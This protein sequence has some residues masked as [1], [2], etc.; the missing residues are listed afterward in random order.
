MAKGNPFLSTLQGRIGD[1]TFRQRKGVQVS[2]KL[3]PNVTNPRSMGQMSQRTQLSNLVAFYRT[4]RALLARAFEDKKTSQSDYNKFVQLN[5]NGETKI[6]LTKQQ[7]RKN[8]SIVAPYQV[9]KGS[10]NEIEVTALSWDGTMTNPAVNT[11]LNLG[12]FQ[13]ANNTTIAELTEAI[14]ANNNG[15]Q[16][17][18]QLTVAYWTQNAALSSTVQEYSSMKV[19]D[20]I[21]SLSAKGTKVNEYLPTIAS[22]ANTSVTPN[23][24]TI[25]F[26]QYKATETANPAAGFAIFQSRKT[27]NLLKV[28][29]Q[30]VLMLSETWTDYSS[31]AAN[32]KANASYAATEDAI[33][34]PESPISSNIVV[35]LEI[36]SL[37]VGTGTGNSYVSTGIPNEYSK[38][39]SN[40][41]ATSPG[42]PNVT[43]AIEFNQPINSENDLI[44]LN[45]V[46]KIW[47][48]S[49]NYDPFSDAIT[50]NT[51]GSGAGVGI[52][53]I[54]TVGDSTV[55]FQ[56]G[57]A[58]NTASLITIDSVSIAEEYTYTVPTE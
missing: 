42:T 3:Q 44:G 53:P 9:S 29:T 56:Q 51:F 8:F 7:A 13:I 28:S 40:V 41:H 5:L 46:G 33:L 2:A 58:Y 27:D 47:E 11:S 19:F 20:L 16:E 32:V 6:F 25:G 43:M 14:I 12:T 18:D 52:T 10:L 23:L 1:V 36:K 54:F 21:L 31:A 49:S 38:A 26:K 55:Y 37:T 48:D 15:W 35:P 45:F 30:K 4:S 50:A 24:Y 34:V 17:G 39:W 22:V 57:T